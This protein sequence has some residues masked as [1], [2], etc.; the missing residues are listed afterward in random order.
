MPIIHSARQ[1]T[2]HFSLK[3]MYVTFIYST[4]CRW[5][6]ASQCVE[7]ATFSY[8]D[9]ICFFVL[10]CN[11]VNQAQLKQLWSFYSGSKTVPLDLGTT[12]A[13]IGYH[14]NCTVEPHKVLLGTYLTHTELIVRESIINAC[15]CLSSDRDRRRE[16]RKY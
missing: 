16:S 9:A 14:Q 2:L 10:I 1:W 6:S 15:S 3:F 13:G 4:H 12:Y 8:N 7:L 5:S 11:W